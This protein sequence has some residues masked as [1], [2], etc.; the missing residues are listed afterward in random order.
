MVLVAGGTGITPSIPFLQKEINSPSEEKMS[1][2]YG[3]RR[4]KLL[5]FG[6]VITEA[7]SNLNRFKFHTFCEETADTK[8]QFPM[9][10]G[11]LTIDA[12]LQTTTDLTKAFFTFKDRLK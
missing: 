7:L 12:I 1:R 10:Q 3:V 11:R 9:K 5:I 2:V 4:P 6:D 8:P